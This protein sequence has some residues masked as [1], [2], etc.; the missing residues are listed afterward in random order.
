VTLPE[1]LQEALVAELGVLSAMDPVGGGC[2]ANAV[3]VT[4]GVGE[5]FVKWGGD[6]IGRTFPAEAQGL[7][8]L[9]AA[10]EIIRVPDVVAQGWTKDGD[11]A[12]LVLEFVR[13]GA[14][15]RAARTMLGEGLA[16]LHQVEGPFYGFEDDNFI[17]RLPQ[18]NEPLTFWPEF[19]RK[20][21]LEPQVRMARENGRWDT[22]WDRSFERLAAMLETVLPMQPL[23]SILHGDLWSG[24]A[25]FDS[26]GRPVL[27]DPAAYYGDRE[28][29]LAMM[30][31]F[32]GFDPAVLEAYERAWPLDKGWQERRDIYQLYHLI[33]HLNHFGD[34]YS[35]AV[36]AIVR[37]Y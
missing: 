37:R 13:E 10:S 6:A 24:N 1:P 33:N 12:Y 14:P 25:L 20:R 5:V 30:A 9:R 7:R 34:S 18:E 35:A 22:A 27:I 31:L 16:Q 8:S 19:F 26:E 17:G 2:I 15:T 36:G 4:A 32:G 29:D 28:T 23:R 11:L 3:R 21:R